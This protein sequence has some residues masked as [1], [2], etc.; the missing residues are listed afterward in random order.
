[1]SNKTE[2]PLAAVRGHV[3]GRKRDEVELMKTKNPSEST[4]R[5]VFVCHAPNAESVFLAG[6]F[7][8]WDP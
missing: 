6:T 1:M 5:T 2:P 7:N 4:D 3:S 8:D